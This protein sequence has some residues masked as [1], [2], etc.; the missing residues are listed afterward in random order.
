MS[1]KVILAYSGGLDTSV[2]AHR[3]AKEHGYDVVAVLADVGQKE[4]LAAATKRAEAAGVSDLVISDLVEEFTNEYLMPALFANALYEGRY[5]LISSLS[6]PCIAAE[7]VR[8]AKSYGARKIAHGCTGKGN[9]QLRFELSIAAL[10]PHCEILAPARDEP[11]SR[12]EAVDYAERHGIAVVA[13]R[14]SPYSI[15]ENLWGRTIECGQLEDPWAPPPEDAFSL[16][17]DPEKVATEPCEVVIEFEKGR[18]VGMDGDRLRPEQVVERLTEIGG[19]FGFGRI[20][21]IE[22][23]R[24]G[25]KS[26]EVYEAPGSLSL[27]EAHRDLEALTLERDLMHEKSRLEPLWSEL[28]YD[29]K[30]YSPLRESLQ[31]FFD[32]T[33]ERVTGEV[34]L[35]YSPGRCQAVGRRSP[36]ALYRK[37]LA[38]Y[39]EGDAF[40][41][42][43]AAGFVKLYGLP[44]RTWAERA[45]SDE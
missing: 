12:E 19:R 36:N 32:R 30:W 28:V 8:V 6:R 45:Q 7:L 17:S 22:N 15:D 38:T 35:R 23:R 27:I 41:H 37:D 24:V 33:Q 2:I 25:I 4:D 39:A 31:A 29:G 10:Y 21:M 1:E 44:I 16:T 40:D 43:D 26:R 18:P 42:Q 13:T 9:D 3:L 34:R 14:T 20:D 5:P 11:M